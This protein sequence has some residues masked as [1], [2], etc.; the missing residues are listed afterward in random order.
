MVIGLGR[1]LVTGELGKSCFRW[2]D[3]IKS[4]LKLEC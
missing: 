1:M 2:N 3:G 4:Q